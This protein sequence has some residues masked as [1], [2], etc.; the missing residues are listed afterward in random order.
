[1]GLVLIL[2]FLISGIGSVEVVTHSVKLAL[3]QHYLHSRENQILHTCE[4]LNF[5]I[6]AWA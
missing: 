6:W 4:F 1:M 3:K 5:K 2:F